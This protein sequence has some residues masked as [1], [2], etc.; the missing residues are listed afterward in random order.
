MRLIEQE[1]KGTPVLNELHLRPLVEAALREDLGWGDASGM[2]AAPEELVAQAALVA[3]AE[4]VLAGLEL[5]RLAFVL[6]DGQVC[7]QALARDSERVSSGQVLARVR[8]PARSLLA[9][10]RVALN[11]VQRLSGIA[12]L[13]ARYVAAVAGTQARIVDTRK[14]TPGLRLLEKYAVRCGGGAN[15]RFGLADAV[16][17]KDNHLALIAATGRTLRQVLDEARQVLPHTTRVEVEIDRLDQLEAALDADPDAILLDNMTPAELAYAVRRV[18]GRCLL[19]AS[20]GVS[21]ATVRAIAEAGVDLVS[22]G[23]L[24]HSAPALDIGLDFVS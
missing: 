2:L 9:A 13:T 1:Q 19:E 14:T 24:T 7:W 8:G 3:R 21:L 5:A 16:M 23:A 11:F 6:L 22:V 10:E 17:L 4:G 20:G 15:H 12:T 18:E